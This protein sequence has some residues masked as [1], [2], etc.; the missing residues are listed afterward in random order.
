MKVKIAIEKFKYL[1]TGKLKDSKYLDKLSVAIKGKSFGIDDICPFFVTGF[2]YAPRLEELHFSLKIYAKDD[3][4]YKKRDLES[5]CEMI[6]V[7][8][9]D[10]ILKKETFLRD[11]LKHLN[12][13]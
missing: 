10:K 4:K 9:V 13:Q 11:T 5:Y 2:K 12:S 3:I 8:E 6:I 7:R 1:D